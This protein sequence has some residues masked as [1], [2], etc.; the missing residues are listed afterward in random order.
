MEIIRELYKKHREKINYL[1]FGGLTT[2]VNF[3]TYALLSSGEINKIVAEAVAWCAAVVFAFFT[4]KFLVFCQKSN[5]HIIREFFGFFGARLLSGLV[6]IG[7]FSLLV[8]ILGFNDWIVKI[9]LS[10]FV[11]IANYV[12]SK[13]LI[14]KK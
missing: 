1:F 10:V 8:S 4:N 5:Q 7:G 6:E 13:F 9:L 11:V 14:F 3:L 2:L 12:L